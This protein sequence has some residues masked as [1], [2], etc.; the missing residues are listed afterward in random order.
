M[1]GSVE[2]EK[3]GRALPEMRNTPSQAFES[4]RFE[5]RL[6]KREWE[7]CMLE[8]REIGGPT[9]FF[10]RSQ[11]LHLAQVPALPLG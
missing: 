3:I 10:S 1:K 4:K 2:W 6:Q 7:V 9:V 8:E 11:A 5:E